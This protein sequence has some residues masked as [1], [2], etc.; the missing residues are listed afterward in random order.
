MG[1]GFAR[2]LSAASHVVTIGTRDP[3]KADLMAVDIGDGVVGGSIE[4]AVELAE[5]IV[6]AVPFSAAAESL[7]AAGDLT[8]KI[9]VDISNPVT[10]DFKDLAIGHTTSAA[11]EI[12][13]F[14]PGATVVKAFN[15]I[16]A[17]LLPKDTRKTQTLQVF[18]ASDSAVAKAIVSDLATSIG[19][20]AVD[21]GPLTNA[22][23]LEPIGEMNIHFG[24]FLGQGP[25][26]APAWVRV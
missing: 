21:A 22:R 4:A 8:S 15:T 16:F 10:A 17:G 2:L 11:E 18:V 5:I 23:F 25:T 9:V 7:K 3:A 20:Q 6:L 26:T 24:Y 19:F 14:V 1:A 12:Q 13:K